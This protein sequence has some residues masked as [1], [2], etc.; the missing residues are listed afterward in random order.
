MS[1][2]IFK[3]WE[4]QKF[5][6]HFDDYIN[7]IKKKNEEENEKLKKENKIITDKNIFDYTIKEF[8]YEWKYSIMNLIN[9]ILHLNFKKDNFDNNTLFFIGFTIIICILLYIL[10]SFILKSIIEE[11]NIYK[12]PDNVK[13]MILEY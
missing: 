8:L 3:D 7:D 11:N 2:E 12:R 10:L 5:N 9:N 6:Q 13:K 1:I 4:P